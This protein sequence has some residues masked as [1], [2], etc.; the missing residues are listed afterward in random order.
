MMIIYSFIVEERERDREKEREKDCISLSVFISIQ[1][2]ADALCFVCMSVCFVLFMLNCL[3]TRC[4]H[5]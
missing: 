5:A 1:L 2:A 3:V 4:L